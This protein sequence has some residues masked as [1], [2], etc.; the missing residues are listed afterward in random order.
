M[1]TYKCEV[2]G[3]IF[4]GVQLVVQHLHLVV[5]HYLFQLVIQLEQESSQD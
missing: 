2:I 3:I 4:N 1:K 5:Q